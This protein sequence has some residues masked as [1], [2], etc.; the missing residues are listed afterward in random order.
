MDLTTGLA[1][2]KV[3]GFEEPIILAIGIP[4]AAALLYAA[5]LESR[6]PSTLRTWQQC[7]AV[8]LGLPSVVAP[9]FDSTD[10]WTETPGCAC[11]S[12]QACMQTD[13]QCQEQLALGTQ[14]DRDRSA[15]SDGKVT[16]DTIDDLLEKSLAMM[17]GKAAGC[18][19]FIG[20]E[21]LLN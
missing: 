20:L 10:S 3:D 16:P 19:D 21:I 4:E 7:I 9:A 12:V 5:G 17:Y 6:R 2:L 18:I 1:S 14:P 15:L 11:H 8:S 13:P